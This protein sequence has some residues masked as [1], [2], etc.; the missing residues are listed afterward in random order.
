M[1][2]RLLLRIPLDKGAA[3]H[4][5][6][7]AVEPTLDD[8]RRLTVVKA[9]AQLRSGNLNVSSKQPLP[10]PASY[11][12]ATFHRLSP[13]PT[14]SSM[15]AR[16]AARVA[17]AAA[18]SA[19]LA[20]STRCR[21]GC[22]FFMTKKAESP[23]AGAS[24]RRLSCCHWCLRELGDLRKQ[25]SQL[26]QAQSSSVFVQATRSRRVRHVC[27]SSEEQRERLSLQAGHT[28]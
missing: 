28:V 7:C 21:K 24:G 17:A 27:K 20:A 8:E 26:S 4:V 13:E 23:C 14:S 11:S 2:A 10:P 9:H 15:S 5:V 22:S 6:I 19:L 25:T 3:G 18:N 12:S 16:C 1:C